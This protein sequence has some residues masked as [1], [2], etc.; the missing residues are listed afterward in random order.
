MLITISGLPGVGTTTVGEILAKHYEMEYISAGMIFRNLAKEKGVSL[1]EFGKMAECDISVDKMIDERHKQLSE[2]CDNIILEGRL[3]G[4]MANP[5]RNIKT[6]RIWL[7]AP[8]ETRV[9]RIMNREGASSFRYEFNETMKREECEQNRYKKYYNIDVNDLSV[10]DIVID[11]EKWDQF[12][13][14]K[15]LIEAIDSMN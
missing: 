4:I 5:P 9:R 13:V 14:A 15:I 1:A 3:A 2:E 11:T 8:L 7:K 6:V 10:Y 12:K